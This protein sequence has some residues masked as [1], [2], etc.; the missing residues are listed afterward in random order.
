MPDNQSFYQ[1]SSLFSGDTMIRRDYSHKYLCPSL[2]VIPTFKNCPIIE[3]FIPQSTNIY[4]Y[5]LSMLNRKWIP[6]NWHHWHYYSGS[7]SIGMPLR[8]P[9][10]QA[11]HFCFHILYTVHQELDQPLGRSFWNLLNSTQMKIIRQ[12]NDSRCEIT[13]WTLGRTPWVYADRCIPWFSHFLLFA[14]SCTC[15][16]LMTSRVTPSLK[17][18]WHWKN[19]SCTYSETCL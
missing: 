8:V 1:I 9:L 17:S 16:V 13:G 6:E 14:T 10:Q 11:D 3:R 19:T 2:F 5:A 12:R 18:T 4:F 7:F 15:D